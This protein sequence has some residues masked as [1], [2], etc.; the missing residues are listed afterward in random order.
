MRADRALPAALVLAGL[1]LAG[2]PAAA[3]SRDAVPPLR[4]LRL[5]ALAQQPAEPYVPPGANLV[6]VTER[7]RPLV[8]QWWFWAAVGAVVVTT[9]AV[10]IIATRP[11]S[12]P[13]S[14]LGNMEAFGGR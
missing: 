13:G 4:P 5:L 6:P 12:A 11:P 2:R 1:L 9:V 7:R 8:Q 10:V 3:G 14:T